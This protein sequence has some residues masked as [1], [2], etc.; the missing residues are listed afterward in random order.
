MREPTS[1]TAARGKIQ[2]IYRFS[3]GYGASVIKGPGSY[4]NERGLWE[5]AVLKGRKI[6]Y[7]TP[8]ADDVIGYLTE[9]DVDALLEK[10]EQLAAVEQAQ[11]AGS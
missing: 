10:I 4:G 6:C 7:D 5:L 11:A 8:I 3:N 9:A 2:N 1:K